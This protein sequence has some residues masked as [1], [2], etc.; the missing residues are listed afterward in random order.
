MDQQSINDT[1]WWLPSPH[2][3]KWQ[4]T[5]N[6]IDH[7][8]HVNNVAYVA[9]LEKVAWSHS[10]ALGLE[11]SEY[12]SIDRGMAI[13][14]HEIDYL[15]ASLLG[16]SLSCATWIIQ[17][18]SKL[19]LTRRFQFIRESDHKTVLGA[20]TEFVCISLSTGKPKRMPRRF[21]DVYSGAVTV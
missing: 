15:G 21:V 14:R 19:K 12:K 6:D 8:N 7:Y 9:M 17:C 4:I 11:F 20:T 10:N 3:M 5:S 2:L 18:D 13:S 1:H 16:D